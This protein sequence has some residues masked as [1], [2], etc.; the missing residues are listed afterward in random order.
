[1]AYKLPPIPVGVPPGSSMWT[2]WYEKVRAAVDQVQNSLVTNGVPVTSA[3]ANPTTS[4]IAPG[5][6]RIWKNTTSSEVRLWVNDNGTLKSVIL[7]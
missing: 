7:T 5:Y 1:M 4:N 3:A 2:D 6:A